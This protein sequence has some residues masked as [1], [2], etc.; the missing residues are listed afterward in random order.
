MTKKNKTPI[1][2]FT[3]SVG[4][5]F[6]NFKQFVKYMSFP[7]LGQI[8]GL[9]LVFFISYFY[10][11]SLPKLIEKYPNLNSLTTLVCVSILI[12]L[13]GLA[14]FVKAF[15]EYLVAYGSVNSMLDNMLKSG[16]VYDFEAHAQVVKR[17]AASFVGIWLL[18]GLFSLI[19]IC[20]LFWVIC[21]I[22]TVYFVL[23][24]QVFT[25]EPELSPFGCAKRSFFIIKGHFASTFLLIALVSVLTY[26]LIP[27]IFVKIFE[28]Y[29]ISNFLSNTILP[30]VNLLPQIDFEKFCI[31][32][33]SNLVIAQ[34]VI[35]SVLVQII[36]QYTLPLRTILW[37]MWY[38][39]LSLALQNK[40]AVKSKNTS[41]PSEKLMKES[42]KKYGKKKLDRNIIR[43][44]TEKDE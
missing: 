18:V 25:Y 15:W 8:I 7:V 42:H 39:E 9:A 22:L 29:G 38:K 5:Y 13:P 19:A 12:T 43:R 30:V 10:V 36:V 40:A 35:Q 6:S 16:K 37:A 28:H 34:F 33:I 4:L 17:R 26:I 27:Q 20:P 11:Q 23:I 2:I 21:G 32:G 3:E 14:I 41:K 44:A 1:S 31:N 24:F